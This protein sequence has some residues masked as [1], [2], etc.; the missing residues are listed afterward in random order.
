MATC[1]VTGASGFVGGH[2]ATAAAAAGWRTRAV[3]GAR[4]VE[5]AADVEVL[6]PRSIG[7]ETAWLDALAS[8]DVV[9]H[10]AG[11]AHGRDGGDAA[12][13]QR[14][15][16]DGALALART[17][18]RAEVGRFVFVS[19]IGVHGN[20]SPAGPLREDSALRPEAPYAES[21]LAAEQAL[22]TQ[23]AGSAT[24]LV[25]VRP[26]LVHGPGA[27]GNPARLLRLVRSG[28]PLPLASVRNRR[29]FVSVANLCAA[30]LCCGLHPRAAG[31]TFLV[32]DRAVLSTP[33]LLR[34][35]AARAGVA[36]RLLPCPPR[37]LRAGAAL[38]GRGGD[39]D[40]LIADLEVDASR[41]TR[42][43]GFEP[44]QGLEAALDAWAAGPA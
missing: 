8:V 7:P 12:A 25:I 26:P 14:V 19:S 22:Q 43:L 11:L 42:L 37:L 9:F 20:A 5:L 27:P 3:G 17:A 23:L 40:R 31:E 6:P 36:A 32:A 2:L 4:P 1:L 41:I 18:V 30:L 28:L 33:E 44:P 29:S 21:K 13:L 34:A 10:L 16:V 39:V 15:N 24:E 35:L 38:V